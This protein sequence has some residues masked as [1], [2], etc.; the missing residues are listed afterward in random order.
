MG[1]PLRVMLE[2]PSRIQRSR[3]RGWRLPPGA[4][5]VDR[6]TIWGN[7]FRITQD[8]KRFLVGDGCVCVECETREAAH[9]KAVELFRRVVIGPHPARSTRYRAVPSIQDAWKHL[10]GADLVCWC[11]YSLPCH[12]DVWLEVANCTNPHTYEQQARL[13][14]ASGDQ[15]HK[16]GEQ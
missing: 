8:D 1:E 12:A 3:R 16:E 14:A 4:I 2:K 13:P 10:R 15:S 6:R 5:L 11:P 7:P 9:A